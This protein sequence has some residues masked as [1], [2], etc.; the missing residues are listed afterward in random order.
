MVKPIDPCMGSR[1]YK[2]FCQYIADNDFS[3]VQGANSL[4]LS[5]AVPYK[6]AYGVPPSAHSLK[7]LA[8]VGLDVLWVLLGEE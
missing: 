1:A 4:G 8:K 2:V 5:A 6:W 3:V 7:M